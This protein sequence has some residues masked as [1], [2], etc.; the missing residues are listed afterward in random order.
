MK[1]LLLTA[2]SFFATFQGFAE[3]GF[4]G[5]KTILSEAEWQRAG[6]DRLSPDQIG[7]IDAAL[8]RH[9]AQGIQQHQTELTAARAAAP[10]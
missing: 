10:V 4:P 2:L 3:D 1:I 7:V 9:H 5:L 6:L 8:I